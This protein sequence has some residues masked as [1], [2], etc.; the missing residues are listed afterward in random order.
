MRSRLRG[1]NLAALP[2]RP[3]HGSLIGL[4]A[5]TGSRQWGQVDC[6]ALH[7]PASN[8]RSLA[9]GLEVV[10]NERAFDLASPM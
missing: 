5:S 4:G 6:H 2:R 8:M 10:G 3:F 7:V 9:P 1:P